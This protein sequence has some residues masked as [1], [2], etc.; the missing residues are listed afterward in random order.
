MH[1]IPCSEARC[2]AVSPWAF[3][4][5]SSMYASAMS[6]TYSLLAPSEAIALSKPF[7]AEFNVL[8]SI[9]VAQ[10]DKIYAGADVMGLIEFDFKVIKV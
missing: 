3:C 1:C 7:S 10:Y 6:C 8:E 4:L 5:Q 9:V 2:R